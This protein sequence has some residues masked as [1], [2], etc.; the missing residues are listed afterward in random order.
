MLSQPDPETTSNDHMT[1]P[2]ILT[3]TT[4]ENRLKGQHWIFK[5][6]THICLHD[7]RDCL[8]VTAN[9]SLV[10]DYYFAA[11]S[12]QQWTFDDE[13][14]KLVNVDSDLCLSYG[15]TDRPTNGGLSIVKVTRCDK[16][17]KEQK[18]YFEPLL[19]NKDTNLN[20]AKNSLKRRQK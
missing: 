17:D 2:I 12:Q 11:S 16:Q 8:T 9:G 10:V 13:E 20:N 14:N 18:W 4:C 3:H 1:R 6:G 19:V 7:G 5:N 15:S